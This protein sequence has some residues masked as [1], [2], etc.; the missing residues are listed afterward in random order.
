MTVSVKDYEEMEDLR[1][2]WYRRYTNLKS[3]LDTQEQELQTLK[4]AVKDKTKRIKKMINDN[5]GNFHK[6]P[7]IFEIIIEQFEELLTPKE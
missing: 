5:D 4:D 3:E 6:Y 1:Q 2:K 7:A